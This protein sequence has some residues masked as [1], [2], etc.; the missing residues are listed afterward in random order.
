MLLMAKELTFFVT[1]K[2]LQQYET[3]R[4]VFRWRGERLRVGGKGVHL[5]GDGKYGEAAEN[6]REA[7][8]TWCW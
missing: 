2:S 1:T 7:D 5:R 4:V 3:A 6:K 8:A